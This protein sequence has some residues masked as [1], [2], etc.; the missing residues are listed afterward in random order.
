[1]VDSIN[2]N[3][4]VSVEHRAQLDKHSDMD[5]NSDTEYESSSSSSEESVD[6]LDGFEGVDPGKL[7][8]FMSAF[9]SKYPCGE[10]L[11]VVFPLDGDILDIKANY[12]EFTDEGTAV[13]HWARV[14]KQLESACNLLGL[15][16]NDAATQVDFVVLEAELKRRL[17]AN[18]AKQNEDGEIWEIRE[19]LTLPFRCHPRLYNKKGKQLATY[20]Q[21]QNSSGFAWGYFW[22]KAW[23]PPKQK[24]HKWIGG[25]S[26]SVM[27][28]EDASHYTEKTL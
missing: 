25:K 23:S 3:A 26:V 10:K 13:R 27:R 6:Y 11:L 12:F 28:E 14:P 21:Q 19:T 18:E 8:T 17:K 22:L 9:D 4:W 24:Q 1:M 7:D 5:S 2:K 16:N 15:G 20:C